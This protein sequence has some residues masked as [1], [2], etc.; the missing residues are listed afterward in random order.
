MTKK[1]VLHLI[2]SERCEHEEHLRQATQLRDRLLREKQQNNEW[3][4]VQG[5]YL[6]GAE[7]DCVLHSD[8]L[9]AVESIMCKILD[10]S[11]ATAMVIDA[12]FTTQDEIYR[13]RLFD[14]IGTT[15]HEYISFNKLP[16][17][18][19]IARLCKKQWIIK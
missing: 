8:R 14:G 10:N 19:I 16:P 13:I 5:E 7:Q 12:V 17:V 9:H 2:I 6:K 15:W 4:P 11:T 3:M 1:Q 18:G